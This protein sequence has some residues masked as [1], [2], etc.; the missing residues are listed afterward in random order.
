MLNI[1]LACCVPTPGLH[2]GI[3]EDRHLALMARMGFKG[4]RQNGH[5]DNVRVPDMIRAIAAHGLTPFITLD[6]RTHDGAP[7]MNPAT[8]GLLV[9]DIAGQTADIP[10]IFFEIDNE[11]KIMGSIHPDVYAGFARA[12]FDA[13][14]ATSNAKVL[15]AGEIFQAPINAR[16]RLGKDWFEKV[17]Q[18]LGVDIY[19]QF[20]GAALHTYTE[21]GGR[22]DVSV[23]ADYRRIAL[24]LSLY[25]TEEGAKPNEPRGQAEHVE[26]AV[27]VA[28]A[29]GIE[30]CCIYQ[31]RAS[32]DPRWDFGIL[33]LDESPRPVALRLAEM[34][35][36][37]L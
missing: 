15:I 30:W 28:E 10:T 14:R 2:G 3:I 23:F 34:M 35:G 13:I 19:R 31:L 7:E 27:R 1:K 24:N 29:A 33:N 22:P 6:F 25:I 11:P 26:E 4:V 18:R 12:G 17:I 16:K 9:A 21:N 5:A 32:R 8:Y 20:D 36:G 37:T